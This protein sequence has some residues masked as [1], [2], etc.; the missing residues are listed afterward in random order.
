MSHPL[1]TGEDAGVQQCFVNRGKIAS[2]SQSSSAWSDC[3]SSSWTSSKRSAASLSQL[4][5]PKGLFRDFSQ[6]SYSRCSS[7][8]SCCVWAARGQRGGVP[9]L[10][11][12]LS[13]VVE[14]P[15]SR[16][17]PLL[18]IVACPRGA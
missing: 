14:L 3:G 5:G 1:P 12:E 10:H 16:V 18:K 17:A 13:P 7:S 9:L 11:L 15:V 6:L 4:L 2:P 8:R